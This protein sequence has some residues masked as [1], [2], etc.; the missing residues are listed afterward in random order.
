MART[1][2]LFSFGVSNTRIKASVLKFNDFVVHGDGPMISGPRMLTPRQCET[3]GRRREKL[4][5]INLTTAFGFGAIISG[6]TIFNAFVDQ[7]QGHRKNHSQT[8][9]GS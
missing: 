3:V 2:P 5:Y 1:R 7:R 6:V 9:S 8:I 4:L